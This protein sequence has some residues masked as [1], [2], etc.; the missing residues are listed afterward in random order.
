MAQL[1]ARLCKRKILGSNPIVGKKFLFCITRLLCV[2]CSSSKH[3]QM[4]STMTPS[5]YPVLDI[6]LIRKNMTAVFRCLSFH[7]SFKYQSVGYFIN[8]SSFIYA[9][10]NTADSLQMFT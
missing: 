9:R 4:K 2:P 10:V 3:M 7:V 5:K 6:D 1:V 8:K